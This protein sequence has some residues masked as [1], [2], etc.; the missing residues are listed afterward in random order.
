M[1]NEHLLVL[2]LEKGL[3]KDLRLEVPG[4]ESGAEDCLSPV[5][6]H[7]FVKHNC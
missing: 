6:I 1:E 4:L 3:G 7:I 2:G 5:V